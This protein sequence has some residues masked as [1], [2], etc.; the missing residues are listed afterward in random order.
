M[1]TSPFI[2][3]YLS[4]PRC[5]TLHG[6]IYLIGDNTKKVHVYNPEANI[7]QKVAGCGA[8]CN[9]PPREVGQLFPPNQHPTTVPSHPLSF[10]PAHPLALLTPV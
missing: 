3:K 7:W 1:I 4:A 8:R 6:L 2:P 9:H 10:L 5:A